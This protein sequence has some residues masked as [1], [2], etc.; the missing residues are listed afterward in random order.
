[1]REARVWKVEG[2]IVS[3]RCSC[4][5]NS[6]DLGK[7]AYLV[8]I[9]EQRRLWSI[10]LQNLLSQLI[11]SF[12]LVLCLA[13]DPLKGTKLTWWR[14]F[15]EQVDIDVVWDRVFALVD[16]LEESRFAATVLTKETVSATVCEFHDSIGEQDSPVEDERDGCD[17]DISA[18]LQRAENTGGNAV[19]ETVLVHLLCQALYHILS[20][21]S[22]GLFIVGQ[23]V[24][25][26]IE[27]WWSLVT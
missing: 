13:D 14:T 25:V 27:E 7:S 20:L 5:Y 23:R 15:V 6:I 9:H 11:K 8:K 19:G 4:Q 16:S 3:I 22:C 17:L 21:R 1:M 26:A 2:S 18:L 12:H 10:I 24:A